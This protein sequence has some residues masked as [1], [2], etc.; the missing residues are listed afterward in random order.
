MISDSVSDGLSGVSA[1]LSTSNSF[2]VSSPPTLNARSRA[3]LSPVT[4]DKIASASALT[5]VSYP[6][7]ARLSEP[8]FEMVTPLHPPRTSE[9]GHAHS[10]TAATTTTT[11]TKHPIKHRRAS[12]G[13]SGNGSTAAEEDLFAR[14]KVPSLLALRPGARSALSIMM[15]A[16]NTTNP[17][18]DLYSAISGRGVSPAASMTATVFF[19]F[20]REDAG[21]PMALSVRRDATVE[22]V[23]GF[24]LWS[25][26]EAGWL[27]RLD[28]DP[29][30]P[31]ERLTAVGWV[32]K[33]AED[34][35]EVD[36]DFPRKSS[37]ITSISK[38]TKLTKPTLFLL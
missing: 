30:A 21:K 6:D 11:T 17:F 1:S 7:A 34:D 16:S 37:P 15:A 38:R 3:R 12:H 35:G 36:E 10:A 18:S 31:E 8:G 20:A 22:E 4:E 24:A 25:Y 19:P 23:L 14:Q 5:F 2:N 28:E 13:T 27:P 9:H 33:I 32:M 26:W 29:N